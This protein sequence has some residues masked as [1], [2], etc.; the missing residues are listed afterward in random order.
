MEKQTY[1]AMQ[2]LM[3]KIERYVL[4]ATYQE[5]T[6][7]AFALVKEWMDNVAKIT[8]PHCDAE[9]HSRMLDVDGTNLVE[10]LMCLECGYGTPALV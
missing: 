3:S 4:H 8:C 6:R 10:T 7:E 2:L 1:E 5:D 9:L